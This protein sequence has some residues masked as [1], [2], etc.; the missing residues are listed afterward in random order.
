MRGRRRCRSERPTTGVGWAG[1]VWGWG[2][3]R[4]YCLVHGPSCDQTCWCVSSP[5]VRMHLVCRL[6]LPV[7]FM[8]TERGWGEPDQRWGNPLAAARRKRGSHG[9]SKLCNTPAMHALS[10]KTCSRIS[11]AL[12]TLNNNP[13]LR[14]HSI[15]RAWKIRSA[16]VHNPTCNKTNN[17]H[18]DLIFWVCMALRN[19]LK[20]LRRLSLKYSLKLRCK[21]IR[22]PFKNSYN[23][24]VFIHCSQFYS[25]TANHGRPLILLKTHVVLSEWHLAPTHSIVRTS[26][27]C[28]VSIVLSSICSTACP[29]TLVLAT[30]PYG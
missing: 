4:A 1:A 7:C 23:R 9:L 13:H 24:S 25:N 3:A 19:Q 15:V 16:F 2:V 20:L 5:S 6:Y 12:Q 28:P 29:T 10:M 17:T 27:A 26:Q 18:T 21:I 14:T 8:D 11:T 22:D 30:A